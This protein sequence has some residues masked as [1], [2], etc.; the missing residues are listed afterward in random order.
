MKRPA[1]LL[2]TVA[3]W[4]ALA[5]AR[6]AFAVTQTASVNANVVKPLT[7][8]SVQN[9]DLGTVALG[10][11]TFASANVGISK[12]G[13][14]TCASANLICTGATQVA[15][16]KVTGTNKQTVL[17]ST[18]NVTLVN[19]ADSSKT[20]MMVVD[21]PGSVTLTSSG[22]PGITFSLG[23]TLT[24]NSATSA[25]DYQGTFQVTVNYQ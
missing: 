3:A 2:L 19:Q 14:F 1:R 25:G 8:V 24:L 18:P 12:S 22:E 17:I 13:V 11:G 9:L 5:V 4:S 23:G 10:P 6:P 16:Y 21:S 15:K 20:L 7:L